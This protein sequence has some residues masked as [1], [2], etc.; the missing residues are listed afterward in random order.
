MDYKQTVFL[1]KTDF[2]MR[3]GLPK[4]ELKFGGCFLIFMDSLG[5]P[6]IS[7]NLC[8]MMVRPMQMAPYIGRAETRF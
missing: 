6:Q 1:P 5:T 7:R 8:C 3:G 2:P 4:K